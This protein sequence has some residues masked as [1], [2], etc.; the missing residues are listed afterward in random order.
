MYFNSAGSTQIATNLSASTL[1]IDGAKPRTFTFWAY[2]ADFLGGKVF[3]IGD[4]SAG[5]TY[6]QFRTYATD[7]WKLSY[8]G[9]GLI[10]TVTSSGNVWVH[11]AL[12]WDGTTSTM[13]ANGTSI[14]TLVYAM[15][16]PTASCLQLGYGSVSTVSYWN[17]AIADF[18]VYNSCLSAT[19]VGSIAN[20][21]GHDGVNTNLQ[22]RWF[23]QYGTPS[24]SLPPGIT[25]S[26]TG[27]ISTGTPTTTTAPS[28]SNRMAIL[29]IENE[30]SVQNNHVTALTYGT[31]NMTLAAS[32][33]LWDSGSV[34]SQHLEIWYMLEAT[35]ATV[36]S[37]VFSVTW[38]N[39]SAAAPV[40]A[41]GFL[42]NVG[43]QSSSAIYNVL[44]NGV[45]GTTN[46]I[47]TGSQSPEP[48]DILICLAGSGNLGTT[49]DPAEYSCT[50]SGWILGGATNSTVSS[51]MG[52]GFYTGPNV[53]PVGSTVPSM[54][55]H[56][57]VNRQAIISFGID[58]QCYIT[59]ASVNGY[60]IQVTSGTQPTY[61]ATNFTYV[62]D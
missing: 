37:G 33:E 11:F 17:G 60:D 21:N 43:N 36:A 2:T 56:G 59:D 54:T 1:G 7:Q 42:L 10:C 22:G 58:S 51:A 30:D 40:Y 24:S 14:G 48:G 47:T 44:T 52:L 34:V 8:N 4:T 46:P 45:I 61:Y 23:T 50:N 39:G 57:T 26:A 6:C 27:A 55:F 19:D 20:S 25:V 53:Q 35:L 18:R 62:W 12:T 41:L 29:C 28:G 38:S 5:N 15:S 16:I 32:Y 13:Y 9:N 49:P 3:N 31:T